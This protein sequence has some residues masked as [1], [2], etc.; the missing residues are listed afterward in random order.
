MHQQLFTEKNTQHCAFAF[1]FPLVLSPFIYCPCFSLFL[2][3]MS[4]FVR[5]K[6]K[7]GAAA[8]CE[9]QLDTLSLYTRRAYCCRDLCPFWHSSCHSLFW[10][11]LP[12]PI[13]PNPRG[14]QLGFNVMSEAASSHS[15][16]T[17]L[18]YRKSPSVRIN[19]GSEGEQKCLGFKT[20]LCCYRYHIM[21]TL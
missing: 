11:F 8:M 12:H 10:F 3:S 16:K 14:H 19:C 17:S 6:T 9:R 21:I 4:E 20:Q 5:H 18:S 1:S 13:P 7:T 2:L 15:S